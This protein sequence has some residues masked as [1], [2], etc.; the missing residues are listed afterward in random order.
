MEGFLEKCLKIIMGKVL[1]Y[2]KLDGF[3]EKLLEKR[4]KFK[5]T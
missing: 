3:L 5:V 1:K 4:D 2:L